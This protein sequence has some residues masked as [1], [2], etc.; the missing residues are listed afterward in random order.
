MT[1]PS[2]VQVAVRTSRD[3]V[4]SEPEISAG[5]VINHVLPALRTVIVICADGLDIGSY[6]PGS[7]D[8]ELCSV[9]QGLGCP[10]TGKSGI[11]HV[12]NACDVAIYG[13]ILL[14]T[15]QPRVSAKDKRLSSRPYKATPEKI[16]D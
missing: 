10:R 4:W 8:G 14:Y 15:K 11:E 12:S 16:V 5:D 1:G 2:P 3:C 13:I 7:S 9:H 6:S